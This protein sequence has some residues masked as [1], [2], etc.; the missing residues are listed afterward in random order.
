MTMSDATPLRDYC[1]FGGGD[2]ESTDEGTEPT[3]E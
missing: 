2:D 3:Q 1:R